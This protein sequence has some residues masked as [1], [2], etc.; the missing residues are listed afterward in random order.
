MDCSPLVMTLWI[1]G[2]VIGGLLD[3]FL[4]MTGRV[5]ISQH[6]WDR[7]LLGVPIILFTLIGPVF[8][9]LHFWCGLCSHSRH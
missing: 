1:G 3:A 4:A 7:P 2:L 9:A 5:T 6:V 8:L